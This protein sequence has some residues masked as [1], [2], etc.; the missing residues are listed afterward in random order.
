M[1][2]N[3]IFLKET[4]EYYDISIDNGD[5]GFFAVYRYMLEYLYF[6]DRA[7]LK[8]YIE[9]RHFLY[10]DADLKKQISNPFE[11]YFVQPFGN[12]QLNQRYIESRIEHKAMVSFILAGSIQHYGVSELYLQELAG[13]QKKY[14]RLNETT[15]G[16]IKEGIRKTIGDKK[17]LG[18]HARGTDYRVGYNNHPVF[19]EEDNYF[20]KIDLILTREN[21][22]GIFLATD[23][24][25]I[26][27]RF[28]KKYANSLYY[29]PDV[30]R[31]KERISVAFEN[32]ERKFHKYNLGLEVLRDAYTLAHC[33]GLVAGIS[34]VNICARIIKKSFGVDYRTIEIIDKGIADNGKD[35]NA[36][37]CLHGVSA[38]FSRTKMQ[39]FYEVLVRWVDNRQKNKTISEELSNRGYGKVA[40]YGM[41]ELGELLYH[42]LENSQIE[43][44]Y[45]IDRNVKASGIDVP[46]LKPENVTDDVDLIIVTAIYYF[47]EIKRELCNKV[48]CPIISLEDVICE[49]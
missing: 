29:Y 47:D 48:S 39:Q 12:K 5:C 2:G 13:M 15:A 38:N 45:A 49:M 9:F 1:Q 42:E 21:W 4:S 46:V 20:E 17:L 25:M 23:D 31:G 40:I 28:Q 10:E 35:F 11:Y 27:D 19:V 34:Q 33:E 44:S 8:P 41:K 14:I 30:C 32:N 3:N 24:E 22:D 16:Y 37:I 6:A 7:G 18:V 36:D 43:V 26:L